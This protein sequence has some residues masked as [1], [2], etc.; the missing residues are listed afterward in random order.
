LLVPDAVPAWFL[1][2]K[3]LTSNSS[4]GIFTFTWL[5]TVSFKGACALTH[6]QTT[7]GRIFMRPFDLYV[8]RVAGKFG[9]LNTRRALQIM[10][11]LLP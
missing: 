7:K 4:S 6:Q 10:A 9:K 11:T 1:L 2:S 5:E 3:Y 8:A